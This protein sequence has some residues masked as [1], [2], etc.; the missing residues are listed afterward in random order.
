[1]ENTY[2]YFCKAAGTE[3]LANQSAQAIQITTST[4]DPVPPGADAPQLGV[5]KVTIPYTTNMTLGSHYGSPAAGDILTL[6]IDGYTYHASNG[7]LTIP[8]ASAD[9]TYGFTDSGTT[10]ENDYTI[11]M[12][13]PIDPD[14]CKMYP[15][16]NLRGIQP[17]AATTTALYFDALTG[18]A[19]DVDTVTLTHTS[20]YHKQL[21]NAIN[22]AVTRPE[23]QG[24]VIVF[25]DVMNKEYYD[26]NPAGINTV[27]FTL[28][29]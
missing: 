14:D 13:K 11:T 9:A 20:A 5:F 10:S 8:T 4:T 2:L 25:A 19:N 22:D 17:T 27:A 6:R 26:G 29:T 12:L 21:A 1:M 15:A 28:D 24:K 18:D 23:N 3:T 7:T 16:A